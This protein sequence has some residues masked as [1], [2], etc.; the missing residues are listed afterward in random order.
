LLLTALLLAGGH[1]AAAAEDFRFVVIGDTRPTF[2]SEDFG[3]FAGLIPKIN[4]RQPALVINLGDLIYGYGVR[5]KGGQWEKYERT[6]KAFQAPYYQLPGNHDVFSKKARDIYGRRFGKFYESFDQGGC[7]FV[8]LDN[9]ED[10]HWGFLGPKELAWLKNDLATNAAAT[11]FIFAH[12]PVWEPE[13]VAPKYFEFWQNTLHPL[14]R[15]SR[16]KAVFGGHSH[17]YGPSREFD[18]IRYFITGG[19]GAELRP[20]YR[21][22]GG[23]YHFLE[24]TVRNGDFDLRAITRRGELT[25]AEADIMGGYQFADKHSSRL[26]LEVGAQNLRAGVTNQITLRNPYLEP[27]RGRAYWSLDS[28][29]FTIEPAAAEVHLPPH[30]STNFTFTLKALREGVSLAALPWLDFDVRAGWHH[31]RF[32]RSVVLL[33]PLAA[34]WRGSAPKLD[35]RLEEWAGAPS[36]RLGDAGSRLQVIQSRDTLCLAVI[37][38]AASGDEREELGFPDALQLGLAQHDR[39]LGFGGD[40]LRLGFAGTATSGAAAKDRAPVHS[41]GELPRVTYSCRAQ[42]G[43]LAFEILLPA[44]LAR[45]PKSGA[46]AHL[47]LSL[48]YPAGGE[49]AEPATTAQPPPNSFAYQVRYGSDAQVPVRFVDLSLSPRDK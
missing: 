4:A 2:E 37:V 16:V 22:A 41:G 49:G 15:A 14:F 32:H 38:P 5:T 7:H 33:Q 9:C 39:N 24:V 47:V 42:D 20:D 1:R 18:G 23:D 48:A 8:L 31:H 19:G 13:R 30:G 3:V 10:Q 26:G 17:C 46:D 25:D 35:G 34:A 29:A 43:H 21:K 40:F 44:A 12:F 36:L 11:V 27:M 6:I 45:L 28:S